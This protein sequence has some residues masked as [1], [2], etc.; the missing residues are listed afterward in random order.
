VYIDISLETVFSLSQGLTFFNFHICLRI[1]I[2]HVSVLAFC[3]VLLNEYD[4]DEQQ[5]VLNSSV[6]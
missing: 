4:G 5:T 3:Q 2:I 1:S 6:A